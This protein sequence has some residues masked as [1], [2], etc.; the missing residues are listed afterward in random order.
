[1]AILLAVFANSNDFFGNIVPTG[2][3]YYVGG[4]EKVVGMMKKLLKRKL[5]NRGYEDAGYMTTGEMA[6]YITS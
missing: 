1:M 6:N 3:H 5:K 4:A 2:F